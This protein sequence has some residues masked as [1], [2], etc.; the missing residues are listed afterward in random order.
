MLHDELPTIAS[1]LRNQRLA[2]LGTL[3]G[4]APFVTMVAFAAEPGFGGVLL[5]LSQLA[6]HTRQLLADP[7][8]SLLVCEPDDRREDPQTLARLTLA[9][10]A[11]V[12]AK[13]TPAFAAGRALYIAKLP[14]AAAL[15]DFGD[16][17]LFRLV[18][19]GARYVGGFG[20]IYDLTVEHLRTAAL[21]R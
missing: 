18:P 15:F 9:G 17:E 16:F 12:V 19:Q 5:H 10:S 3:A 13:D 21:T 4:G 6:P 1:L 20:R 11:A 14:A 2:A 7:R 8:A